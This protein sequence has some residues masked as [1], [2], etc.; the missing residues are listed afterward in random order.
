MAHSFPSH[1]TNQTS[2]GH[3]CHRLSHESRESETAT[4]PW[5]RHTS[6]MVSRATLRAHAPRPG[7]HTG[8]LLLLLVVGT[9]ALLARVL[10]LDSA[11]PGFAAQEAQ[12]ALY[13]QSIGTSDGVLPLLPDSAGP[14]AREPLFAW[15]LKA[16]GASSGWSV[17]GTRLA[18]ALAGVA[19]AVACALWYRRAMGT[20][21]GLAG[22]LLVALSF[23]QLVLSRQI[24]AGILGVALLTLGLWALWQG[25]GSAYDTETR[26]G[27]RWVWCLLAGN[28]F[29]LAVYAFAPALLLVPVILLAGG[30]LVWLVQ[31]AD[32]RALA[33]GGLAL[34]ALAAPV[35]LD[36]ALHPAASMARIESAFVEDGQSS[37]R[38]AGQTM[39][40]VVTSVE[41]LLWH[42]SADPRVNVPG[43]AL[44]DPLL[45][46]WMVLGVAY[47]AR[48]PARPLHAVALLWLT[49]SL[50]ISAVVAP[51]HPELLLI[52]T[53]VVF[54]LPLL[55]LSV[56][57]DWLA[58]RGHLPRRIAL[59]LVLITV[60]GSAGVS[61][62]AYV[63]TWST[64][65][66]TREA[67][68]ADLRE[69][70][71]ALAG[72]PGRAE[73]VYVS[74]WDE[75]ALLDFHAQSSDR[76]LL[77]VDGRSFIAIPDTGGRLLIVPHASVPDAALL[78][79]VAREGDALLAR[80]TH[81]DGTPAWETWLVGQTQRERLPYALPAIRFPN[82]IQ[83]IGYAAT[84]DL[85]EVATTG[86]LP[87]PPR[88]QIVLFWSI[89][90]DMQPHQVEVTLA[91]ADLPLLPETTE[92]GSVALVA[93]PQAGSAEPQSGE[94][95][96]VAQQVS[97]V[98]AEGNDM[99]VDVL[100]RLRG[101]DGTPRP[102]YG[103]RHLLFGDSVLL[104]RVQY[105]VD[106]S[107]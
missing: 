42:G 61:L 87:D 79:Y 60:A 43:R 22:G 88:L 24:S 7:R 17:E 106:I 32:W 34:L 57:F 20:G 86:V 69:A 100:V 25:A 18:T 97:V 3:L 90:G 41:S 30:L 81:A 48:F 93:P 104:N 10:W 12:Q 80:G 35:L 95:V 59:G 72:L 14:G 5:R 70:L 29:G 89:P 55:S 75:R 40:G 37:E 103:P 44:L 91:A 45:A 38:G 39:R 73:P 46:L 68:S 102:A 98:V 85:G 64:A 107:E 21:W 56:M 1:Q 23:W 76:P 105:I 78:D 51:G 53:P 77:L 31:P 67:F 47:A 19:V 36:A 83:L 62:H 28:A 15:W 16:T 101:P 96:I 50:V 2:E 84:P 94:R 33:W 27:P 49:G 52:A 82:R 63:D 66:A 6:G 54:L 26:K 8:L 11:P 99:I 71:D 65:P 58:G 92:M 9:A 74:T 13:A 4:G